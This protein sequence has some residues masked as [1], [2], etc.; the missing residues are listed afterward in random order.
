MNEVELQKCA[1]GVMTAIMSKKRHGC[2]P[3]IHAVSSVTNGG[4]APLMDSIAELHSQKWSSWGGGSDAISKEESADVTANTNATPTSAKTS[5]SSTSAEINQDKKDTKPKAAKDSDGGSDGG[6]GSGSKTP[7]SAED[8]DEEDRRR[9]EYVSSLFGDDDDD[10][11]EGEGEEERSESNTVSIGGGEIEQ[12]EMKSAKL[13][14]SVKGSKKRD[15]RDS[16][17]FTAN[18]KSSK[19]SREFSAKK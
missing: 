4:M 10:D 19:S 1:T 12:K 14:D 3:V 9:Q 2:M 5:K 6:S 15:M 16:R 11:G 18:K 7:K 8:M 17:K 13:A